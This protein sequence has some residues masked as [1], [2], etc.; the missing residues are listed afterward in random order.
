M[1][2]TNT[3][4]IS[5]DLVSQHR[6]G[7]YVADYLRMRELI[8]IDGTCDI[9]ERI[10]TKFYGFSHLMFKITAAELRASS[11]YLLL[12]GALRGSQIGALGRGTRY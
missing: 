3:D 1:M 11:N 7:Y 6:F 12:M 10:E 9:A 2:L 8:S 4:E 5:A